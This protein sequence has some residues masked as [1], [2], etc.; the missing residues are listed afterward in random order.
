MCSIFFNDFFIFQDLFSGKVRGIDRLENDLY[1]VN[2]D[3][4]LKTKGDQL[5]S[6]KDQANVVPTTKSHSTINTDRMNL[7][8]WNK[9]LLL[10]SENLIVSKLCLLKVLRFV[11]YAYWLNNPDSL[12]L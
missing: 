5:N 1:V 9:R 6:N 3:C 8:L 4:Q 7:P 10:L 12:F 11:L 2:A